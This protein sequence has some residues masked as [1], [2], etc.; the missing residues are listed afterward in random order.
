MKLWKTKKNELAI[1]F[2]SLGEMA[3]DG[4]Y[5]SELYGVSTKVRKVDLETLFIFCAANL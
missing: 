2:I 1:I 3:I 5:Y 4:K